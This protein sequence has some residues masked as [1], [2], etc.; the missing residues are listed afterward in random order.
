MKALALWEV[1]RKQDYIFASNKLKE[2]RGASI[3][4]E[5]II[6]ELPKSINKGYENNVVYNGGGNSLYKFDD[7]SKAKEFIKDISEEVIGRYPGIQLF[8]TALEYDEKKDK[9]TDKVSYIHQKLNI[10]KNRR[11]NSGLQ[12]SFGIEIP[13]E[14]TKLPAS[15]CD[16]DEEH[17]YI[18]PDIKE[19]QNIDTSHKNSKKF[20]R[21]IPEGYKPI[22]EFDDL[23]KKENKS[24]LAVVHIDGNQMG[25]KLIKL[26]E[27]F[28]PK[29]SGDDFTQVNEDYLQALKEFSSQIKDAYENSFIE[30]TKTIEENKEELKDITNIEGNKFPVIP[31][32]VAGDDITYITNG[33][34]GIESARIFLEYLNRECIEIYGGGKVKLNACAGV[35]IAKVSHPFANTYRLAEDLCNNAKRKLAKEYSNRDF[36]LVDW[37]IEQGD[38]LGSISEIRE[39]YYKS[40]DGYDLCMRPLYLNNEEEN[41]W[42]SY[43]N[44]MMAFN[45]ITNKRIYEDK[46][47][48]N[49]IKG[50]R[51]VFAK[52]KKDTEIYLKSNG[53]ENFFSGFWNVKVDYCFTDK[54][55]VYSDA[56]EVMDLFLKLKEG[57]RK[58]HGEI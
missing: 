31:I 47:A 54:C 53:I 55:C 33:K 28:E 26:K 6:E 12:V 21:L 24:Y 43:K 57:G 17:R 10:K 39:K 46:I 52:G 40:L 19:K 20:K 18:S 9:V 34:I 27:Y 23:A 8:M 58:I 3:I 25:K 29:Y 15:F 22:R 38:L 35:A 14:S 11:A 48:R 16:K 30:M 42:T 1:S 2:N 56:V 37:H 32:I 13:C 4:I 49:K 45:D 41:C 50:L 51:D 7:L 5:E 44:F 36:S